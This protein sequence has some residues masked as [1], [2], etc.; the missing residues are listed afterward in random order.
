[1]YLCD[2]LRRRILHVHDHNAMEMSD[3]LYVAEDMADVI[4]NQPH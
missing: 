2:V 3:G 4:I 1:M